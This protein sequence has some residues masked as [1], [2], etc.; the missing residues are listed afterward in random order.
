MVH[1]VPGPDPIN[2]APVINNP[3]N[4]SNQNLMLFSRGKHISWALK[5][6]GNNKLPNPPIKMGITIKKIIRKACSETILL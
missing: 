5:S 1:P 3:L 4:G 6:R 2:R